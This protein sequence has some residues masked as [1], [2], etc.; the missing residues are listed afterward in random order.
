MADANHGRAS[1]LVKKADQ[2]PKALM[3]NWLLEILGLLTEH[4]LNVDVIHVDAWRLLFLH[5]CKIGDIML[6]NRVNSSIL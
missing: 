2:K 1:F 4:V 6:R 5:R 3:I